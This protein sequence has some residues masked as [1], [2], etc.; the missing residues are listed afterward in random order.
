M[1][2]LWYA[3]GFILPDLIGSTDNISLGYSVMLEAFATRVGWLYQGHIM[4]GSHVLIGNNSIIML[5]ASVGE[6]SCMLDQSLVS[7]NLSVPN[8]E[9]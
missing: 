4:I 9:T 5:G 2:Y 6:N 8:G 1:C 3:R 7:E